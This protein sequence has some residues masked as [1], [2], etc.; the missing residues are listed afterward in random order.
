[1][2]EKHESLKTGHQEGDRVTACH[3]DPSA[4]EVTLES[5][6]QHSPRH[7]KSIFWSLLC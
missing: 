3:P 7:M 5:Q 6:G 2:L 4:P 1:M